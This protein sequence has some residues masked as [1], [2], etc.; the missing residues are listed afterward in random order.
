MRT[1]IRIN[2]DLLKRAKKHA[3]DQG[4]TLT[5]LVEDALVLILSKPKSSQRKRVKLPVSK[6]TGGVLPGIDLNRSSDLE[7]VMNA[8]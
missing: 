4:R 2:D 7:E 1:T 6:A 5:S 3:A 8:P